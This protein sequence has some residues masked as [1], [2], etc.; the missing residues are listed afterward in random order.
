MYRF[1]I[2]L[3]MSASTFQPTSPNSFEW[4]G[5]KIIKFI[6]KE[7][8]VVIPSGT[9]GIGDKAFY[10]CSFLRSVVISEGV[11]EIGESAFAGCASLQTV[12]LS[13]SVMEIGKMAFK[14][15]PNVQIFTLENQEKDIAEAETNVVHRIRKIL[16]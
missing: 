2:P 3:F 15:F 8:E 7:T 1:L 9:T 14:D 12:Y 16:P 10:N 6:G 13:K 5:W 4:E 11:K